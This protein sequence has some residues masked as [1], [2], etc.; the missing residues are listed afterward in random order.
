MIRRSLPPVLFVPVISLAAAGQNQMIEPDLVAA[1]SVVIARLIDVVKNRPEEIL[2][3]DAFRRRQYEDLGYGFSYHETTTEGG[4]VAT[5]LQVVLKDGKPYSFA[6]T[7]RLPYPFT[8]LYDSYRRF[9][10]P[11]FKLDGSGNPQT[12][13]WRMHLITMP[14]GDSSY[15][16]RYRRLTEKSPYRNKLDLLMTPFSGIEYGCGSEAANSVPPN[17]R[18]FVELSPHIDYLLA[19]C[20]LRSVNPATRLTA[21]EYI[22][23]NFPDKLNRKPMQRQID[24]LLKE[25]P[26]VRTIRDGAREHADSRQL[27]R[28]FINDGCETR[29]SSPLVVMP[30]E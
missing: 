14:V 16:D 6:V 19:T 28:S 9:Y 15:I 5:K 4:Y 27:V 13:Y 2:S 11:L 7:P 3:L 21:I 1:D 10:S 23:R 29:P 17:R 20:M 22:Q 8:K 25:F 24:K 26:K 18:L 12:Y 30:N